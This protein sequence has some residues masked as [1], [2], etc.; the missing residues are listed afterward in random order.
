[1][2]LSGLI[3]ANAVSWAMVI[4]LIAL[5]FVMVLA[6]GPFGLILL[7]LF[8]VF[9]CTSVN[10]RDD[11]PTWGPEVFRARMNDA[12]S[13]EQRAARLAEKHEH[14]SP[15]RFYNRCGFVLIAAGMLAFAW[16]QFY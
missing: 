4:V 14:L 16:R 10:L 8:T 7:G 2:R 13:P 9:V 15:L 6:I 5:A 11:T 1:M 3:I 12:G